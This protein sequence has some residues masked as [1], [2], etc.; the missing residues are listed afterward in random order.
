MKEHAVAAW[1]AERASILE[2]IA[3]GETLKTPPEMPPLSFRNKIAQERFVTESDEIKEEVE[4]Y[5]LLRGDDSE[6]EELN[7]REETMSPEEAKRVATAKAY[8]K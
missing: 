8:A 6:D 2:R 3:G 1:P 7:E 5:R 4:R